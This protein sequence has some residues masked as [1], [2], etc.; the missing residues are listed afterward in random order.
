MVIFLT[1]SFTFSLFSRSTSL[2]IYLQ[3]TYVHTLMHVSPPIYHIT[4]IFLYFIL[5]A[6]ATR[7]RKASETLGR[8]EPK[9]SNVV[10]NHQNHHTELVFRNCCLQWSLGI[11][12]KSLARQF[13]MLINKIHMQIFSNVVFQTQT[14]KPCFFFWNLKMF[15]IQ[16]P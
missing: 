8:C 3:Y 11:L 15:L 10:L 6:A 16:K 9:L 7:Y 5:A 12:T 1:L 2:I 13:Q 4:A 14:H